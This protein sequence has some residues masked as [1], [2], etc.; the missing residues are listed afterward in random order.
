MAKNRLKTLE[1]VNLSLELLVDIAD[2]QYPE[3]KLTNS[4]WVILEDRIMRGLL[5]A[6]K[7]VIC[8][9]EAFEFLT[10]CVCNQG[11]LRPGAQLDVVPLKKYEI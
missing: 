6:M 5:E 10:N 2:R 7:Q 9:R 11:A 4:N 3:R 8:N 1:S